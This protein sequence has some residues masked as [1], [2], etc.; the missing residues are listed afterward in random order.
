MHRQYLAAL[1]LVVLMG[2]PVL[3]ATLTLEQVVPTSQVANPIQ[4]AAPV[5]DAQRLFILDRQ[6]GEIVIQDRVSG[7][8]LPA[9]FFT[10]PAEFFEQGEPTQNAFSF[11]FDPEFVDTKKLY[12]SFVDKDDD[13]RVI[14]V[15]ASAN[16]LDLA[17]PASVRQILTVPYDPVGDGTHFGADLDFG[18]DGYLYI[19]TGDSDADFAEVKSQDLTSLQGK[20]LRVNPNDDA[21]PL[22]DVNN[23]TPADGNP[24]SG[25]VVDVTDAIWALGLR[26]PFQASFDPLTGAYYIGDVGEGNFEEINIGA[27]GANFGWPAREGGGAFFPGVAPGSL[28]LI[29]PLYTYGHG[30]DPF[31]GLSVTGGAVYRGPLAAL[32]GRYFF[33]DYVTAQI[34]SFVPDFLNKSISELVLW[35][36][37]SPDGVP[38]G[39]LSFGV[40]GNGN[41][42]I[43]GEGAGGGVYLIADATLDPVPLPAGAVLF[44]SAIGFLL[45]GG[46]FPYFSGARRERW[47]ASTMNPVIGG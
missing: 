12:V 37:I 29:N 41:L 44:L 39:V 31:E 24:F 1:L 26:N 28:P 10:L 15:T 18:P 8:I 21:F 32:D 27:L 46:S 9:P 42:Y 2:S 11:A 36:L 45:V 5:G 25:G 40:D 13:L 3:G 43:V 19:T 6:K 30:F 33:S 17:D 35:S 38:T 47:G 23:F 16:N 20:I 34:W 4:V 22:D 14:E 7:D